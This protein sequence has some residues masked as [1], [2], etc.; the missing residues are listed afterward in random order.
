MAQRPPYQ[1]LGYLRDEL[2]G[3]VRFHDEYA[4]KTVN[5]VL[6]I[7]GGL[8]L[9]LGNVKIKSVEDGFEN[10]P[11]SFIAAT[12]FFIS[13]LVLYFTARKH[14][15]MADAACTQAAYIAVFYEKRPSRTVKVGDNLSW[16]LSLF[17]NIANREIMIKIKDIKNKKDIYKNKKNIEYVVLTIVSMVFMILLEVAFFY[18]NTFK[19]NGIV[20]NMSIILFLM[21]VTYLLLSGYLLVKVCLYTLFLDDYGMRAKHL[22]DYIQYALYTKHDTEQSLKDRLGYVWNLVEAKCGAIEKEEI[23]ETVINK[24]IIIWKTLQSRC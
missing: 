17:E 14:Y 11:L 20:Q 23:T 1:E 22:K 12:I 9:I 15:K 18:S 16:E 7:W 24:G 19:V 8:C 4:H 2:R 6:I 21:C 13:N 5:T 3:L 10:I